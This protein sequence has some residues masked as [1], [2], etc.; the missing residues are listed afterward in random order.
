[1][2]PWEIQGRELVNCNCSY[3][4]PCQFNALPTKGYCEAIG[5]VHIEK[6]HY[7]TV[8]LDALTVAFAFTWPGPISSWV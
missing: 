7:G 6:G 4:C 5:A 1:M 8:R 2:T 3:G